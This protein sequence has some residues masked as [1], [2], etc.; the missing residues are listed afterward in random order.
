MKTKTIEF[1]I[2]W[3]NNEKEVKDMIKKHYEF[4]SKKY[5]N[6]KQIANY[7]RTIY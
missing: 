3:G 2:K 7:I 6:A 5:D 1:L 4:A